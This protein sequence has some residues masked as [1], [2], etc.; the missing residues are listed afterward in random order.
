MLAGLVIAATVSL[1]DLRVFT[2]PWRLSPLQAGVAMAT[3][4]ATVIFAPRIERGIVVGVVLAIAVHLWR[5]LRLDVTAELAE[6]GVL[7]L[8]PRG[9]LYYASAPALQDLVVDVVA[10]HPAARKLVVHLDGLGRIDLSGMLAIR[11]LL[12]MFQMPVAV[13]D[14]PAHGRRLAVRVL[15]P[16]WLTDER[17][18]GPPETVTG[19]APSPEDGRGRCSGSR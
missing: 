7:R 10:R 6:D 11:A 3:F 2:R 13:T 12:D 8:R 9:V 1:L 19:Q 18:A 14:V 4:L 5:E 15:P 16:G 17:D